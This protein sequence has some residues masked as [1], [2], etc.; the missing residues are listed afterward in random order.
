MYW[1]RADAT[2]AGV[3]T[4]ARSEYL[5]KVRQHSAESAI[6]CRSLIT[7]AMIYTFS[8]LKARLSNLMSERQTAFYLVSVN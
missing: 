6:D 2:R 7:Y 3:F 4:T 1:F 5:S 8:I